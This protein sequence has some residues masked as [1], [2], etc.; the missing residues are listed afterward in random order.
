MRLA[1]I[2][3]RVEVTRV[4]VNIANLGWADDLEPSFAFQRLLAGCSLHSAL[5]AASVLPPFPQR[6]LRSV[7]SSTTDQSWR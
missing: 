3:Q 1:F 5:T 7:V 4:G 6:I 2:P